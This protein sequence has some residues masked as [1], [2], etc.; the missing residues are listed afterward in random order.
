MVVINEA[1]PGTNVEKDNSDINFDK[2]IVNVGAKDIA[3]GGSLD[4]TLR[5]VYGLRR[6][7]AKR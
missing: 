6:T 2:I 4:K 1:P 3:R 5:S 7:V